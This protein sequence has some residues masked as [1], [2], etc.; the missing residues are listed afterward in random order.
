L[1]FSLLLRFRTFDVERAAA[2]VIVLDFSNLLSMQ[3]Q[4]CMAQHILS[5]H[6]SQLLQLEVKL[7]I[8]ISVPP[9]AV[10]RRDQI[11]Y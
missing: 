3:R 7:G 1:Q 2:A 11:Y 9:G 4:S 10:V 8:R 6:S 5:D